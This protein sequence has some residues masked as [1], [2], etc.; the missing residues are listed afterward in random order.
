MC[1]GN[2][3]DNWNTKMLIKFVKK[4]AHHPHSQE[5]FSLYFAKKIFSAALAPHLTSSPMFVYHIRPLRRVVEIACRLQAIIGLEWNRRE[6]NEIVW[7]CILLCP[8]YIHRLFVVGA[9]RC[10]SFVP[11][12]A[13]LCYAGQCFTGLSVKLF[14][15]KVPS[16]QKEWTNDECIILNVACFL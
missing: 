2:K 9:S 10:W 16:S 8:A 1:W 13:G 7:I 5:R 15:S 6:L 12:A 11:C 4:H 3:C 14:M